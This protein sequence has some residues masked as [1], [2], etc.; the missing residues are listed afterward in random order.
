MLQIKT[1]ERGFELKNAQQRVILDEPTI[2][3]ADTVISRA[4]EYEAGGVEVIYGQTAALVAWDKLQIVFVFN[5]DKT[6]AFEKSQFSPCDV[7]VFGSSLPKLTKANFND[8]L[9]MFDPKIVVIANKTDLSEI[10]PIIKVEPV[11]S[12]KLASQSLPE[13]GREFIVLS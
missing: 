5:L 8:T 12:G 6:T 2:S 11:E 1:V 10:Q 4:G 3:L 13:E 7:V 9:E